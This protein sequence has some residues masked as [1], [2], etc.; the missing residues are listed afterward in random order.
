MK[1]IRCKHVHVP[2]ARSLDAS[3]AASITAASQ[4]CILR[5]THN[6]EIARMTRTISRRAHNAHRR[7]NHNAIDKDIDEV[8]EN[9]ATA[10]L[11][12]R[13][14]KAQLKDL[15]EKKKEAGRT[16]RHNRTNPQSNTTV[17][18]IHGSTR[19]QHGK[20]KYSIRYL[21]TSLTRQSLC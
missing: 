17:P 13:E 2:R 11:A 6:S 21:S 7:A 5:N 15:T 8:R 20:Y 1:F 9:I 18:L 4:A 14:L 19:M 12:N 10:S 16:P 3:V